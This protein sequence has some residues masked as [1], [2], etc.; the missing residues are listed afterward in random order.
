MWQVFQKVSDGYE[1]W[2]VEMPGEQFDT[3]E[4]AEHRAAELEQYNP[5]PH[6]YYFVREVAQ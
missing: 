2:E 5:W 4:A 6:E 1:S 3:E